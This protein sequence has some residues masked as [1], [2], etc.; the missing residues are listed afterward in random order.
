MTLFAAAGVFSL[1]L[2]GLRACDRW[3]FP[4]ALFCMYW[5]LILIACTVADFWQYS[6]TVQANLVFVIGCATFLCGGL[7]ASRFFP[8]GQTSSPPDESR[9]R[10]VRRLIWVGSAVLVLTV[11]LFLDSLSNAAA[12][13]G[14][15]N[16]LSGYRYVLTRPDRGG[17]P[18]VYSSIGS[19]GMAL[20]FCAAWLHAAH[21]RALGT[22]LGAVFGALLMSVLSSSRTNVFTL[23]VGVVAILA[24]GGRIHTKSLVAFILGTA[25]ITSGMGLIMNKVP[26]FEFG[27]KGL[28]PLAES[29]AIYFVGGPLGFANVMDIARS[30]GE[31][32][33][34]LRFFLQPL[35]SVGFGLDLPPL[36]LGYFS[37][38]LGN[39]YTMYFAYWL[40]GGWLGV[41]L[42]G[43]LAGLFCTSIAL[44]ARRGNAFG[45]LGMGYVIPALLNSATGVGVFYSATH[46]LILI[47]VTT[48]AWYF[49]LR[50]SEIRPAS[51]TLVD[52]R[53]S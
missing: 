26:G 36:V 42:V 5:T 23:L 19:I 14:V 51:A 50:L 18:R 44:L 33:L 29:L 35:Q 27:L 11:P 13:Q 40:D 37:S 16:S 43:L 4:P 10:F 25:G 20:A 30:V 12:Q 15:D 2:I 22:L 45:G 9:L 6:L 28:R 17:V 52:N 38:E 32:G 31:P 47:G 1:G 41:I 24:I 8:A 34:S 21:R 48:L 7:L 53:H 46:W 49:P 39:V 3:W